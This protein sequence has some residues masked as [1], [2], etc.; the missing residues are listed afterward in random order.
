MPTISCYA[1]FQKRYPAGKGS[2][3]YPVAELNS[4]KIPKM[5]WFAKLK[6]TRTELEF[7]ELVDIAH[8]GVQLAFYP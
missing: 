8:L 5:Q 2:G 3:L 1:G 4:K 6:W 7:L